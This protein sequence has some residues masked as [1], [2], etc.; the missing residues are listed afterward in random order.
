MQSSENSLSANENGAFTRV[1][2]RI[3]GFFGAL[4]ALTI[5]GILLLVCAE[6]LMRNVFGRST[7]ISDEFA[8]YLNAAAVFLGLGYTLRE[9]AFIRVDSLYIKMKGNMLM[10]ARWTFT[11]V[12]MASLLILV[13]YEVKHVAYL[14]NSNIRSD[15]LTET[16]LYIP[17][18][19]IVLGLVVLIAQL[20]TYIV[21]G[22]RDV[23]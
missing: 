17:Q 2:N 3:S 23:P 15:S 4:S 5:A 6:I 20:A 10:A 12:T 22:V 13:Y 8:G 18:S 16:A 1:I 9:G 11:L 19:L 14:Y 21:K 7:M